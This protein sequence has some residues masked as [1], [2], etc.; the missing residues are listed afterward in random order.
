MPKQANEDEIA[1]MEWSKVRDVL[2]KPL[3]RGEEIS[4]Q[5]RNLREYFGDERFRELRDFADPKRAAETRV[6][7]GNVVVLPAFIAE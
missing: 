5:E 3:T 4:P 2:K 7:L 6:E 1:R